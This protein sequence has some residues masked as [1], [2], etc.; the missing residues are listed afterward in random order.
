MEKSSFGLVQIY[1]GNGKGKTTASLGLALRA[2][3]RGFK[4]HLVQF[5]K[6]GI[7]GNSDFEEY[8]ELAALKKF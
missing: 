7:E 6:G 2:L 3:G 4:V 1:W 8:G 5:M